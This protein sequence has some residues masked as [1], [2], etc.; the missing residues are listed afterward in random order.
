MTKIVGHRGAGNYAPENTL[1][2]FQT[3]INIGCDRTEL[4]VR[5]TK[6]NEVVVI[7][8]KEINGMGFVKDITLAELKKVSLNDGEKIPTLQEVI[9]VCKNKTD[10]QIE[11]KAEG[12]PAAVNQLI[13]QNK[14]ENQVVITSFESHL[15]KEIKNLNPNLKVGL[16]IHTDEVLKNSW[17]LINGIPLDFLAL[18]HEIV[19]KE[20]IDKT[21]A[22]GKMAH[23]YAVNDKTVGDK[24]ISMGI[25]SIGTDY[26]KLFIESHKNY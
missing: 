12:T 3:A 5:M 2:S 10:L 7:H 9:N 11:L 19:T 16:L 8:D 21:H 15:L 22:L 25:D 4:D 6:D 26:P 23:A 14:L 17:E 1:K 13:L 18:F 24:L 20:L